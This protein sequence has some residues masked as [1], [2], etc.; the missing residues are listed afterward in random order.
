MPLREVKLNT[1]NEA[2]YREELTTLLGW[3]CCHCVVGHPPALHI[4]KI[5]QHRAID[6]AGKYASL[7]R[8]TCNVYL[9]PLHSHPSRTAC[10]EKIQ[11][12]RVKRIFQKFRY[13]PKSITSGHKVVFN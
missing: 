4:Y 10:N 8:E 12:L 1:G 2:Q 3:G 13:E 6:H 7:I 9:S 5:D 11:F